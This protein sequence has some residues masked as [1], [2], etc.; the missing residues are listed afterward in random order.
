MAL[1]GF[2][3]PDEGRMDPQTYNFRRH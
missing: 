3:P 2:A 1:G